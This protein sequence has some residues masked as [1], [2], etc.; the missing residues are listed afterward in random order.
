MS[1]QNWLRRVRAAL[2]ALLSTATLITA[3]A[4]AQAQELPPEVR[5]AYAGGPARVGA[6][7]D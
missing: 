6:G 3:T 7:Q 2:P 1:F 5:F 4:A